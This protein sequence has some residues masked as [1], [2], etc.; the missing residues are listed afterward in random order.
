VLRVSC[1]TDIACSTGCV[2]RRFCIC[3]SCLDDI[4]R[5][6]PYR[7]VWLVVNVSSDCIWPR[8]LGY[9]GQMLFCSSVFLFVCVVYVIFFRHCS[10]IYPFSLYGLYPVSCMFPYVC[11]VSSMCCAYVDVFLFYLL[12]H[13]CSL[14][15]VLEDCPVCPIY[16][17]G[18]S[19]HFRL[20]MPLLSYLLLFGCFCCRFFL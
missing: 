4:Y 20:Y 17:R 19:M 8:I 18:Q 6:L 13:M 15:L 9:E 10:Y 14:F 5:A 16:C 7:G 11:P 12:T 3:T 1:W 2:W